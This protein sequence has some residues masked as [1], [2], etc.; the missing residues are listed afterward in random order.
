MRGQRRR[1]RR[2][3]RSRSGWSTATRSP[4]RSPRDHR[5]PRPWPLGR[6][7]ASSRNRVGLLRDTSSARRSALWPVLHPPSVLPRRGLRYSFA[8]SRFQCIC[9]DPRPRTGVAARGTRGDLLDLLVGP[10]HLLDQ[11]GR[12]VT[13]QVRLV[14]RRTQLPS[15]VPAVG[16][17]GRRHNCVVNALVAP[18]RFRAACV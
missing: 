12:C 17:A 4:R 16:R 1:R 5:T 3:S 18:P 9:M 14:A 10:Q 15:R 7:R 11:C 8:S 13:R 2:R 6:C